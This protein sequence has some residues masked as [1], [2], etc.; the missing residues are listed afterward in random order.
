MQRANLFTTT[1]AL[2]LALAMG[3]CFDAHAGA[4]SAPY[5]IHDGSPIQL[6]AKDSAAGANGDHAILL[7]LSGSEQRYSARYRSDGSKIGGILWSNGDSGDAIAA[8]RSGNTVVAGT[9][10][11]LTGIYARV[12][13]R[14]GTVITPQFRVDAATSSGTPTLAVVG[15]NAD[16]IF[17]V[18]WT[19]IVGTMTNVEYRMFNRDGTP[20]SAVLTLSSVAHPINSPTGIAIDKAGNAAVVWQ[21]RD[22]SAP[23]GTNI[24][25]RRY[26]SVGTALGGAIKVSDSN[27]LPIFAHVA[28]NPA[29]QLVVSWSHFDAATSNRWIM[30]QRYT[31]SGVRVGNNMVVSSALGNGQHNDVAMMDDGSFVVTWDNDNRQRVPSSIP[32][33]F[34]RQ[35]TANGVAV[36]AETRISPETT[37]SS[38]PIVSMDLAGNYTLAWSQWNAGG[39]RYDLYGRR[40]V[41]DARPVVNTLV[42]G[43]ASSG[44]SGAMGSSRFFRVAIPEGRPNFTVTMT[45]SGDADMLIRYAALPSGT[46][47][48]IY[49]GIVGSNETVQV[50]T[51]PD[52]EFYIE[53]Y[54][55]EAY[56]NL[57]PRVDY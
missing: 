3:P 16:G 20:R 53:V 50:N 30:F 9:V 38:S 10:P 54:G 52:G 27:S 56:S 23:N 12:Y 8:D 34:A 1:I 6:I 17:A 19:R 2:G 28:S 35:Y 32:G 45:G 11:G 18:A 40:F 24:W 46:D 43:V 48:D 37:M 26:N 4:V 29:G 31:S 47:F 39:S 42:N 13:N 22:F 15:M 55:Y 5:L 51:P 57:S 14:A 33:A 44:W 21:Q 49:P 25:L 36:D 7:Q 41:M